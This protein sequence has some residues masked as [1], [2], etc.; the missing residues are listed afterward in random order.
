M[1][2]D[3]TAR[4]N[5]EVGCRGPAEGTPW[6]PWPG[7][8]RRGSEHQ[9]VAR[10]RAGGGRRALQQDCLGDSPPV[11][12]TDSEAGGAISLS[13]LQFP[14]GGTRGPATPSPRGVVLS[15]RPTDARGHR[16]F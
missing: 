16:G 8:E 11:P 9:Q 5:V 1:T 6:R 10:L 15:V 7:R 3:K 4:G 14:R 13:G 12:P 2:A